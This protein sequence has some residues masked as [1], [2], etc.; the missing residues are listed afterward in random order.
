MVF[1]NIGG[2]ADVGTRLRGPSIRHFLNAINVRESLGGK[3]GA[4]ISNRPFLVVAEGDVGTGGRANAFR[5]RKG[6]L[7]RI[8]Q[9]LVGRMLHVP[10]IRLRMAAAAAMR[11]PARPCAAPARPRGLAQ[12]LIFSFSPEALHA[13][14]SV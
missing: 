3:S 11:E 5:L 7:S 2:P 1:L 6:Y 12:A 8:P 14:L 13:D 4:F 10:H 9:N